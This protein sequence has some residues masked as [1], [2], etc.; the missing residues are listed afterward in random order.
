[1]RFNRKSMLKTAGRLLPLLLAILLG[2]GGCSLGD[3][4]ETA[5]AAVDLAGVISEADAANGYDTSFANEYDGSPA[6][7]TLEPA[8]TAKEAKTT[9]QEAAPA[10][11]EPAIDKDGSYSS[12]DDVALYIH[13]YGELPP[14]YMTKREAEELGWTGGSLER[15]APGCCI[16]GSRFGNYEGLLPDKKGRS[17]TECDIDTLGKSSRGTKRIVFSNDGLIYYTDDHYESFILLYDSEGRK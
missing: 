13:T 4:A 10:H 9:T 7:D 11:N 3:A 5:G 16:G 1:M 2:I 17:W 12:K 8:E 6:D 15:Y 14:N